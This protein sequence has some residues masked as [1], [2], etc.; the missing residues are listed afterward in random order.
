MTI[1]Q[2]RCHLHALLDRQDAQDC[3]Y[4]FKQW[5][6]GSPL[7]TMSSSTSQRLVAQPRR[8][9]RNVKCYRNVR[10]D[11]GKVVIFRHEYPQAEDVLP[12]SRMRH[13]MPTAQICSL[14]LPLRLSTLNR[15]PRRRAVGCSC[16]ASRRSL[17]ILRGQ[18]RSRSMQTDYLKNVA[19][20]HPECP[21]KCVLGRGQSFWWW[22]LT[23][24]RF[25]QTMMVTR[26]QLQLR[27]C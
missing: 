20:A 5:V 4:P 1:K 9:P 13:R 11:K 6:A 15:S 16:P 8:T 2:V 3:V 19:D 14:S 25:R 18:H 23:G 24:T 21:C 17:T 7:A 12:Q 26:V 27:T 22:V 10:V